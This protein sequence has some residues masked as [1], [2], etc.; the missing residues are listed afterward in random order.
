MKISKISKKEIGTLVLLAFLVTGVIYYLAFYKP[1]QADL[2][3]LAA[4]SAELDNQITEATVKASTMK[5]MQQEIDEILSQPKTEITEIAPYDNK[6]VV[7]NMLNGILMRTVDYSLNF[8]DPQI[9]SDG[10]VRRNVSMSFNCVSYE[11]A[12]AVI[13]D[14]TKSNWRCLVSNCNIVAKESIEIVDENGEKVTITA[15]SDE[16]DEEG[17]KDKKDEEKEP[18][19]DMLHSPVSVTA[20]ITFFE[21]EKL[22]N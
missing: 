5:N 19:N 2:R 18:E 14:L 16:E 20:T 1:M 6:E 11:E 12:K 4:Q 15:G 21:S 7:F 13:Q 3:S 22:A 17:N 9:E 10:F 8:A